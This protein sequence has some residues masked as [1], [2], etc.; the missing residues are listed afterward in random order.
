MPSQEAPEDDD[1]RQTYN[2]APGYYGL[3]YRADVPDHGAGGRSHGAEGEADAAPAQP[4]EE[5]E[6]DKEPHYKLQAMK[7]GSSSRHLS[8][9]IWL[10]SKPRPHPILDETQPRLRLDDEDDKLPRRL[11]LHE[12]RDVEHD[13]AEEKMRRHLP[14][15]LRVAEEGPERQGASAAFR[16][17][18]G[19]RVDVFRWIVGLRQI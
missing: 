6:A 9:G 8:T 19:W 14:G 13:E 10:T 15:L 2:F 16:E 1:V 3:V 5:A 4:E 12:R 18:K 17:A 11:P 7:W